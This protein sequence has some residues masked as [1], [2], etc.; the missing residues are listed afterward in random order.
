M[1]IT[2]SPRPVGPTY[3]GSG[4]GNPIPTTIT[5][6]IPQPPLQVDPVTLLPILTLPILP[7]LLNPPSPSFGCTLA[8]STANTC[9]YQCTSP[10]GSWR[11]FTL[12][13]YPGAP[14][15]STSDPEPVITLSPPRH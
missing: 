15:P 14:C 7:I 4:C 11:G 10:V 2:T 1:P 9:L 6:P 12:K 13:P 8:G 3:P 5:L